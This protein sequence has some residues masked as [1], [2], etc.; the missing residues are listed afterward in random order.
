MVCFPHQHFLTFF[1]SGVIVNGLINVSI[2][3]IERRFDL[4]SSQFAPVSSA[5][6]V[7]SFFVLIP[8]TYFGGR[9]TASKPRWIGF[10]VIFMAIGSLVFSLPHF[11]AGTYRAGG[12]GGDGGVQQDVCLESDSATATG[13]STLVGNDV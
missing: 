1:L 2:S 9:A 11:L 7:A 5:Y 13:N 10:G 6:D 3:T 4:K 12:S 8:L